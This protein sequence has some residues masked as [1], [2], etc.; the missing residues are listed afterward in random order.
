LLRSNFDHQIWQ[1]LASFELPP[2][3]RGKSAWFVQIWW[4]VQSTLFAC[5]PQF[6]Y[7]WRRFLLRIFGAKVGHGAIIRPTVK[8]TYPWKLHI[9]NNAWIGDDVVLYTLENI[10][11]GD[12]AVVS[13]RSYLCTGSHDESRPSFDIFAKPIVIESSAWVAMDVFVAPGVTIGCA[14]IV[15]SRSSVFRDIPPRTVAFGTPARVVRRRLRA[16]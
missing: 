16:G 4:I 11:I 14:A 1:N 5:S 7:P 8:I 9:G 15:G 2:N 6:L 10:T 12:D 3:F 13:Q